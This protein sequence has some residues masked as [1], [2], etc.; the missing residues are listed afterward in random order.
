MKLSILNPGNPLRRPVA[1]RLC[2]GLLA[3]LAPSAAVEASALTWSGGASGDWDT[4]TA[5]WTPGPTTWNNA[6]PD[7]ATF[8]SSSTITLT[9]AITTSN[10][11]VNAG[12]SVAIGGA[13]TLTISKLGLMRVNGSGALTISAP[14]VLLADTPSVFLQAGATATIS[15]DISGTKQLSITTASGTTTLSGDNSAWSGGLKG[16][17]SGNPTVHLGSAT[18]LGSGTLDFVNVSLTLRALSNGYSFNNPIKVEARG[19][20]DKALTID[21]TNPITFTGDVT[22]REWGTGPQTFNLNAN[23]GSQATFTGAFS[24]VTPSTYE[25]DIVKGGAG[26][27]I[28]SGANTYAGQ[29]TV[30]AG[31]LR[32]TGTHSAGAG[33]TVNAGTLEMAGAAQLTTPTLTLADASSV[34]SLRGGTTVVSNVNGLTFTASGATLDFDGGWLA[35]NGVWD[36]AALT[37]LANSEFTAFGTANLGQLSFT[38]G[39]GSLSGFTLINAVS[40]PEPSTVLLLTLG[41]WIACRRRRP[42]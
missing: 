32:M 17:S 19:T 33:Y 1:R 39:S 26:T 25:T 41:G 8:S 14:V 9:E 27:I 7:G 16:N 22:L 38:D 20:T 36:L 31:T 29:T 37:G 28:L 13:N 15:G 24:D 2:M 10:I 6:T 11:L 3:L 4:T 30:N 5:N 40:V 34:V 21:G 12:Y 35:L 18:A 42:S 23:A